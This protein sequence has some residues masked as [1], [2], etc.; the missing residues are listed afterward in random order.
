MVQNFCQKDVKRCE[1][2]RVLCII[3]QGYSQADAMKY[4]AYL[5]SNGQTA[6]ITGQAGRE[7]RNSK[8]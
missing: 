5:T 7:A 3:K 4:A 8:P 2:T 1:S 6:Y